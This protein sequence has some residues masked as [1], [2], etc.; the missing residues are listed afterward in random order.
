M[1]TSLYFEVPNT[2]YTL[3]ELAIWDIIYEHCAYFCTSSLAWAFH[4]SGFQIIDINEAFGGQFLGLEAL[5][6][7][8]KNEGLA[9]WGKIPNG[10]AEDVQVFAARYRYKV[11]TWQHNLERFANDGRQAV[12]WGAG[13]KGVT[14]LNVLKAKDQIEYV[15]DINPRKHGAHVA[16]TGQRIVPPAFLRHYRPD[17]I[18]VMNPIYLDE[19]R[20]N[21]DELG[22]KAELMA[23]ETEG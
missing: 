8:S 11:E 6:S 22:L 2:E 5:P 12:V 14:F 20:Q 19:I 7:R 10:M 3:R 18:L 17:I 4:R 9:S 15:V 1:E 23:V 21:L 16:G 13:S